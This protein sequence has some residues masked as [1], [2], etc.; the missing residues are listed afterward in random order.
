MKTWY[1]RWTVI[2]IFISSSVQ[3]WELDVWRGP[4][5]MFE[6]KG[7]ERQCDAFNANDRGPNMCDCKPQDSTLSSKVAE[8]VGCHRA[9]HFGCTSWFSSTIIHKTTKSAR[10]IGCME[11]RTIQK[12]SIWKA[13][14]VQYSSHFDD[15]KGFWIDV[16]EEALRVL[17]YENHL[18]ELRQ[19]INL[20]DKWAG[21]LMKIDF[22]Q[23][24]CA[25]LKFVGKATHPLPRNIVSILFDS[26]RPSP[27][28]RQP[29]TPTSAT[30]T[31]QNGSRVPTWL[32]VVMVLLMMTVIVLTA[33]I[34]ILCKLR[35]EV[36]EKDGSILK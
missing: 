32:Y 33:L 28:T 12:I 18:L 30:T 7:V 35:V 19:M 13:V 29:Q 25:I 15:F 22:P 36:K 34:I 26:R 23:N 20:S 8:R 2:L 6:V 5:D 4:K 9:N 24:K 14:N 16:T 3:P 21:Q 31:C 1:H 11:C 10:L 27:T 17:R